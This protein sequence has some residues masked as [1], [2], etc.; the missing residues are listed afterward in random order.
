MK[1]DDTDSH[2][3]VKKNVREEQRELNPKNYPVQKQ[4]DKKKQ[5][6]KRNGSGGQ[7]T[8]RVA[9]RVSGRWSAKKKKKKKP[10]NRTLHNIKKPKREP[11]LKNGNYLIMSVIACHSFA[12]AHRHTTRHTQSKSQ[13]NDFA[14]HIK[15]KKDAIFS[16]ILNMLASA[17]RN[18]RFEKKK[19]K[20]F[21][22]CRRERGTPKTTPT[23]TQC[24]P[25]Q[26]EGSFLTRAPDNIYYQ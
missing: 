14:F 6:R 11:M 25:P 23:Q 10:Q 2:A 5:N 16:R 8:K 21:Y 4:K 7:N 26:S 9:S 15:K 24:N 12:T 18:P 20:S 22:V 1:V 13:E 17:V 3:H 19:K